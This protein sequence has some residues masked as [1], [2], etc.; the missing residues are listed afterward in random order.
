MQGTRERENPKKTAGR[1]KEL[2]EQEKE[3]PTEL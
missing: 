1:V 3:E 2:E